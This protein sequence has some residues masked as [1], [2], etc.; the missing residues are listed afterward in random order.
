M[1]IALAGVA[2]ISVYAAGQ[3][4]GAADDAPLPVSIIS[5]DFRHVE[6]PFVEDDTVVAYLEDKFNLDLDLIY[7][8]DP[9]QTRIHEKLN[10]MIAAGDIPDVMETRPDMDLAVQIHNSL[11][12][13]D[14]LVDVRAFTDEHAGRFP[15]VE[16]R[17]SDPEADKF[18]AR[19]G[20]LYMI[21]RM[22]GMYNHAWMIRQDW[23]DELG[24]S[25]PRNFQEMRDALEVIVDADPDGKG[26]T[27]ITLHGPSFWLNY[28]TVGYVGS[29]NWAVRDG[30]YVSVY[31]LP[32]M[33]EALKFVRDLYADG[34]LDPEI[35][36]QTKTDA[37][38]KFSSGRAAMIIHSMFFLPNFTTDLAE[39]KQGAS[40]G[41]IP[42]EFRGPNYIDRF[43]GDYFWGA[44]QVRKGEDRERI[45]QLLD[46]CMSDQ[47]EDLFINGIEG[48]HY[49][50]Q[51][52]GTRVKNE[53]VLQHENWG[54][55]NLAQ[56]HAFRRLLD[57][58]FVVTPDTF[59][60]HYEA[61]KKNFVDLERLR[62]EIPKMVLANITLNASQEVGTR[63]QDTVNEWVAAFVTGE[64]DIDAD[65]EQFQKE[66]A[67]SGYLL[68]EEEANERFQHL[69]PTYQ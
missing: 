42:V 10:M 17:I 1:F 28:F 44:V 58:S 43:L 18:E 38:S 20:E 14:E 41:L 19:D 6:Q 54:L 50:I 37:F 32:E 13:A 49:T 29:V 52:D 2:C 15:F 8:A 57:V 25:I 59:G 68:L 26:T 30:R 36:V 31:T 34:L 4:E 23:F 33:R 39:Y 3:G 65:W 61:V 12:D 64:R 66:Y 63:P 48:V 24:L 16:E 47:G 45:F 7:V 40:V 11:A 27:G 56:Y 55:E 62:S 53:E 67:E 22:Y 69:M 60:E 9:E 46:F 5:R 51:A 21:P 35:F